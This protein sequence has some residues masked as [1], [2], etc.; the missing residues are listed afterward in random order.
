MVLEPVHQLGI[1]GQA[2]FSAPELTEPP[3][4]RETAKTVATRRNKTF[5]AVLVV[6]IAL[7]PHCHIT[8]AITADPLG[9]TN[10]LYKLHATRPARGRAAGGRG[11]RD[12][13]RAGP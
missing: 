2:C 7:P 5:F 13:S 12:A 9:T 3:E 4:R 6:R 1:G 10:T 8:H 11:P